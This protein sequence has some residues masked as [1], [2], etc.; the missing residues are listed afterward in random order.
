MRLVWFPSTDESLFQDID[1][2][3][4]LVDAKISMSM[5]LQMDIALIHEQNCRCAS[6]MTGCHI[7]NA[8]SDLSTHQLQF[9]LFPEKV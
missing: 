3:I 9:S 7:I 6:Q 2:L 8:I 4:E 1:Q 5:L